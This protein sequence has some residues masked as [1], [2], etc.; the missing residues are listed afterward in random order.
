MLQVGATGTNQP[1]IGDKIQVL[2]VC[3][4]NTAMI[5]QVEL[6]YPDTLSSNEN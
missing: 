3:I 4:G 5:R 6:N 1:T 2:A